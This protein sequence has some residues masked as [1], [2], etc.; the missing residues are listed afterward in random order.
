MII[1][2]HVSIALA[3]IIIASYT[4]IH[5]T[6]RTLFVS[7][8]LIFGTIASGTYFLITVPSHILQSCLMGLAYLTLVTIMTIAAHVRR[9]TSHLA[10][11]KKI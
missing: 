7:Y 3:S 11:E 10:F 6:V 1:L 5:P 8:G 2:L 9:R 4:F